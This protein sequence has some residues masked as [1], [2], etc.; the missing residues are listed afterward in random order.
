MFCYSI[1]SRRPT[2]VLHPPTSRSPGT[3]ALHPFLEK[4]IFKKSHA[5]DSQ[6]TTKKQTKENESAVSWC[7]W[8]VLYLFVDAFQRNEVFLLV[9]QIVTSAPKRHRAVLSVRGYNHKADRAARRKILRRRQM[10]GIVAPINRAA[11]LNKKHKASCSFVS[12]AQAMTLSLLECVALFDTL[13]PPLSLTPSLSLSHT[14]HTH[15]LTH[16]H[17]HAHTH[18]HTHK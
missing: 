9:L 17:T 18:T 2:P 6:T 1:S 5:F 15:T 14:H 12:A 16:T 10:R 13:P 7:L 11:L 4:Y 3:F 8:G